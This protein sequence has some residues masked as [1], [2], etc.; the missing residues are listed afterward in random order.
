M[1]PSMVFASG[2][3]CC[4][5]VFIAVAA[6]CDDSPPRPNHQV[7]GLNINSTRYSDVAIV[8]DDKRGVTCYIT[9]GTGG[10]IS[11]VR[12]PIHDDAGAKP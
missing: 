2:W 9:G 5:I 10:G 12:D 3:F 1:K 11:C 6:A 4:G 7:D 8:H